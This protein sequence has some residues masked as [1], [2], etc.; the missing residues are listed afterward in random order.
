MIVI[1]SESLQEKIG[2]IDTVDSEGQVLRAKRPTG[3]DPRILLILK[4]PL[5]HYSNVAFNDYVAE[6][7]KSCLHNTLFYIFANKE[8]TFQAAPMP[9]HCLFF[10]LLTCYDVQ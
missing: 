6:D 3:F 7:A 10:L 9:D 8:D 5:K 1:Q 2:L 4:Y